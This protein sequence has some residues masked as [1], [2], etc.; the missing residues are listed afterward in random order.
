M[1]LESFGI[2]TAKDVPMLRSQKVPDIGPVLSKRLLDWHNSLSGSFRP[3]QGLPISEKNRIAGRFAPVILPF[4]QS[5]QAAINE[6]DAILASHRSREAEQVKAIATA[7]Q[8][9]AIA[10]AHVRAMKVA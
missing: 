10:E 5:I 3:Q 8:N 9:L 2:E 6:L 7:V 4:G 1:S